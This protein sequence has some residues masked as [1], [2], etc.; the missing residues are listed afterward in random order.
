MNVNWA[1]HIE[2]AGKIEPEQ[3]IAYLEKHGW[4]YHNFWPQRKD[5]KI[6]QK[7]IDAGALFQVIIPLTRELSDYNSAMLKAV[8]EISDS[9]EAKRVRRITAKIVSLKTQQNK[10]T[11][12]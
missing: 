3:M 5:V 2:E 8:V 12:A 11:E 9:E 10:N 4:I 1:N 7:I 6:Y